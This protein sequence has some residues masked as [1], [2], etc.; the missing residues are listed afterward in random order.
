MELIITCA[1]FK[2]NFKKRIIILKRL[3]CQVHTGV[4]LGQDM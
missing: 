4:Y 1:L 2:N 3:Q